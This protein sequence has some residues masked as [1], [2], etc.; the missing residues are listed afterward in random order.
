VLITKRIVHCVC[1][2]EKRI[3]WT[4]SFTSPIPAAQSTKGSLPEKAAH[5]GGE[6]PL[7][8]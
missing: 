6:M 7:F 1:F 3:Q 5:F 8:D 4:R 2:F